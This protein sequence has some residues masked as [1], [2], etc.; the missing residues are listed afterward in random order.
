MPCHFSRLL[1]VAVCA[2]GAHP[3]ARADLPPAPALSLAQAE[4]LALERDA[5][6]SALDA[7]AAAWRHDAVAEGQLPDPE[8]TFG[9]ENVPL[10]SASLREDSMTMASVGLMQRF[11]PAGER[12]ARR[13]GAQAH[14]GGQDAQAALRVLG[15]LRAVRRAYVAL[16]VTAVQRALVDEGLAAAR[17]TQALVG[18]AYAGGASSQSAVVQAGLDALRLED[19]ARAVAGLEREQRATLA[20][21]LGPDARRPLPAGLPGAQDL[22]PAGGGPVPAT[23]PALRARDA[24]LAAARSA[25]ALAAAAYRPAFALEGRYGARRAHDVQGRDLPDM[26]SVMATVSLPLL[27]GSRQDRRLAAARE[28]VAAAR[29][30]RLDEERDLNA[31][32]DAARAREAQLSGRLA[33]YDTQLLPRAAMLTASARAGVQA[34]TATPVRAVRARLAETQLALERLDLA[35]QALRARVATAYLE[36]R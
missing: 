23:H 12:A 33:L 29:H 36:G 1:A 4:T 14:A 28:R 2:L 24:D 18:A 13:A 20:R 5:G 26:G 19:R 17:E 9:L 25:E 32:L 11:P 21:W 10:D 15:T 8:L 3:A 16:A 7:R 30:A 22:P 27:P 31:R 34:G 6:R 35:A